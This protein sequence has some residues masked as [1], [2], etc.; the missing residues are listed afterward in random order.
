MPEGVEI[1]ITVETIKPLLKDRVI[2]NV[3]IGKNSRY[4]NVVPVGYEDFLKLIFENT[5]KIEDVSCKGKFIYF[6]FDNN[7]YLMNTMGMSG[8]WSPNEGK[9]VC[10]G[11]SLE[12]S[13][14]YFNDPRHFG[15]IKFT[16]SEQEVK[17]KLNKL[18]WDP[19]TG[20]DPK[21][22]NWLN[23][24][25][26]TLNKPIG[27]VL[28]DQELFNG[29]GNYLRA[30]AL[31]EAKISPWKLCKDLSKEELEKLYNAIIYVVD[32]SYKYQGATLLTY[33]DAYG[34]EGNYSSYFKVYGKKKDLLGN[35]VI[36]ETSPEGR[37]IH[38]CP[39][40]QG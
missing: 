36:S 1:K 23:H 21:W 6:K 27:Q 34:N 22:I 24:K 20:L 3:F 2:K 31:Y 32:L 15:T 16:N 4:K 5:V 10:F 39:A 13:K 14:M 19:F 40:V 26:S 11:F 38:W 8:Q 12:D 28:L 29:I 7:W 25:L 9:H 33:K 18:G 30:E 35:Q 17:D 37:T